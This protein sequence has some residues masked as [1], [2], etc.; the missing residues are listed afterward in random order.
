VLT[1]GGGDSSGGVSRVGYYSRELFESAVAK[2]PLTQPDTPMQGG[3]PGRR[4]SGD[5]SAGLSQVPL[6]F[7]EIPALSVS[8]DRN[9]RVVTSTSASGTPK[10]TETTVITRS[11]QASARERSSSKEAPISV[12]TNGLEGAEQEINMSA[13]ELRKFVGRYQFIQTDIPSLKVAIV[14]LVRGKLK[15]SI[16]SAAYT[17]VPISSSEVDGDG[18]PRSDEFH[19]KVT[20]K[21]DLEVQ[22]SMSGVRVENLLYFQQQGEERL[23]AVAVPKP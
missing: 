14:E 22:F 18:Q 5:S 7:P 23:F 15:L 10:K 17:L 3:A 2:V 20:G 6:P 4:Q 1:Y 8:V 21:P 11:S 13:S 12:V 19:F 16:G 9:G